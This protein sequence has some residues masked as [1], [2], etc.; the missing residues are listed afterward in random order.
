MHGMCYTATMKERLQKF[1]A[2]AG[3]ASRRKAE[4]LISAGIVAVNGKIVTKLG[5]T[6]DPERDTVTV[7]GRRVTPATEFRYI[8]LNKPAGVVC[9]KISQAGERTVYHLVPESGDLAIAGRLDKDSEGL[10]ILS[11]DGELVN[12]LTHPRYQ[13]EKEYLVRTIKPLDAEALNKLR[14][15]VRLDEGKAL[16]DSIEEVGPRTYRV[17][18]HQGWKRQ[19]RRMVGEV[20]NDVVRL[21]RVRIGKLELGALLPSRWHTIARSDIV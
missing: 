11:N 19:I 5:T 1:I 15:G 4:Q 2:S 14:R 8:A 7:Q 17:V 10:V 18:L 21:Q 6:V 20:R 12:K 3:F 16:V 13:H 9:S